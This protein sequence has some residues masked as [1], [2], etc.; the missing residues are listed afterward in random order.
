[1]LQALRF[2][3]QG[4]GSK[5]DPAI[6]KNITTTL[7]GMLGHDEVR[8]PLQHTGFTFPIKVSMGVGGCDSRSQQRKTEVVQRGCGFNVRIN[9]CVSVCVRACLG[10]N[11]NGVGRLHR[12]AVRL[13]VGGGA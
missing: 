11:T 12:R 13:P 3:I 2:V 7:L 5:V 10:C 8:R 6:R 1:M 9:E 4:A